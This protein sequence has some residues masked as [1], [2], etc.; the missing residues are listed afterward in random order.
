MA[1][2]GEKF[3]AARERKKH[4]LSRAAA[5]TRIKIQHLERMEQDDFSKMPAPTYAKGFIRMYAELLDLDPEPL[6]REYLDEHLDADAASVVA[7]PP[8]K[9]VRAERKQGEGVDLASLQLVKQAK[10][11]AAQ[12][13]GK[14]QTIAPRLPHAVAAVFAVLLLVGMVRC[15][16]KVAG[17]GDGEAAQ[18]ALMNEEA[19]MKEPSVRYLALPDTKQAEP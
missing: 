14:L 17:N 15:A 9:K 10:K 16:V 1:T 18:P 3:V 12:S 13:F 8:S 6:V 11:F 19:L 4:S 2:M 7:P 5:L